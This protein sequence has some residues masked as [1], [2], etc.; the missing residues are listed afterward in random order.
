MV[1]CFIWKML[2]FYWGCGVF[3]WEWWGLVSFVGFVEVFVV[4]VGCFDVIFGV[5]V[6]EMFVFEFVG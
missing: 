1:V 3:Y 4:E 2:C 6:V 5:V